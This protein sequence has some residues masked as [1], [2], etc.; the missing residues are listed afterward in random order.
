[1]R[2]LHTNHKKPIT[3]IVIALVVLTGVTAGSLNLLRGRD[4]PAKQKTVAATTN[5]EV[6]A[7]T[8]VQFTAEKDKT[9]L[10]QLQDKATVMVKD[11]QY[12]P[13]VDSVNGLKGGTD[14][15]YWSY[16]VD[17]QMANIGAGE[18]VTKGGE[19]IVWKF[20]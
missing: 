12:G 20:E 16:Y 17:G 8:T 2:D 9:V 5:A 4:E 19:A 7:A 18:Y 3:L 11:S 13:Y 15:K 6:K 1:M 10:E 14:N